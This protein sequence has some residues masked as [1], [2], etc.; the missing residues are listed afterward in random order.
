MVYLRLENINKSFGSKQVIRDFN[1]EIEKE[2]FCVFLGPSGCGKSTLLNIIAGLEQP[3]SGKIYLRGKDI[4][5]FAPHKRDMAMVFQDYAL[6]PH[7]TVFENIA[8][9]LR[10]KALKEDEIHRK[11]KEVSRILNIEDKLGNYPRS[12]S[13]GERQRAATG[14][15]IVREPNLFLFDEPLSNLDARLRLELRKEFLQLQQRLRK[16]SLYVTHDQIEALSLGDVIA[17][18]KEGKIQQVSTP[19]DLYN[20]PRNLFVAGFIGTPPMNILELVVKNEDGEFVLSKGNFSLKAPPKLADKLRK[21]KHEIIFLGIRPSALFFDNGKNESDYVF[22]G[23]IRLLEM[24]GED[25]LAYI[26]LEGGVEIRAVFSQKR[27]EQK[28]RRVRLGVSGEDMYFF[29]KNGRRLC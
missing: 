24:L 12:L 1:L 10:V 8:F 25:M 29:E 18:L 20:Q 7:L 21:S 22:E 6:Y 13:G 3:S 2:K 16:T 11:V 15:A 28:G 5:S 26:A 23:G 4:T 9:G 27:R 19:Y 17:V 14:R